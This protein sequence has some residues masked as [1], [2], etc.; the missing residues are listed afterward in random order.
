MKGKFSALFPV[1]GR[2]CCLARRDVEDPEVIVENYKGGLLPVSRLNM[3]E[4]VYTDLTCL[5]QTD[6]IGVQ[7]LREHLDNEHCS[8][9]RDH[10]KKQIETL[11][12]KAGLLDESCEVSPENRKKY[13]LDVETAADYLRTQINFLF[14]D[15]RRRTDEALTEAKS[16]LTSIYTLETV[17]ASLIDAVSKFFRTRVSSY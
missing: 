16:H 14:E 2:H 4:H 7:R 9:K 17:K 12:A 1:S 5:L 10:Y 13:K 3:F 15:K 8:R 11:Q 6:L